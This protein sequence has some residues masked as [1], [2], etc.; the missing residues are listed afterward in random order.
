MYILYDVCSMIW[1]IVDTYVCILS[2][3]VYT[4]QC[5]ICMH[6]LQHSDR[7]PQYYKGLGAGG[8]MAGGRA[9]RGEK[10]TLTLCPNPRH[11]FLGR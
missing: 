5:T 1:C 10:A 4:T 2:Y 8:L 3:V 6:K 11:F 7:A 9:A